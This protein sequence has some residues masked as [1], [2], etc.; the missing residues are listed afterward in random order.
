MPQIVQILG[1]PLLA[2]LLMVGI[3]GVFGI[4]VLKREV[5][6]IDISLAQIAAVG[7]VVAHLAFHVQ[8]DSM[9]GHA[10]ALGFVL[11]AA[12]FY[13]LVRRRVTQISLEAV[14]G[15]SYAIAAA[16][17]LFLF[18]VAAGHKHDVHQMLAGNLLLA[19]W[20][21]VRLCALAFFGVGACF[22]LLRARFR[23]ISDDYESALAEGVN[24]VWW[25]F[26]FYALLGVVIT[27]AVRL[28]GVVVV[29]AMLIIP[30][31]VS[32]LFSERWGRRLLITW[33]AGAAASAAGLLF[34]YKLDFSLGPSLGLFLGVALVLAALFR[35]LRKTRQGVISCEEG[36]KSGRAA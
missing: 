4:H 6:F 26:L 18:G 33:A 9:L 28:G 35:R 25:D 16:S 17:A 7:G 8:E 10:C 19:G 11:A 21:D 5:I 1:L 14:I 22:F 15:V 36:R 34:A 32:A 29:F 12:A 20:A 31:T 3:L 23:R 27:L 13:A 24:V 2:C 30:A